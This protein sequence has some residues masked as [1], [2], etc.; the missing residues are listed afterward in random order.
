MLFSENISITRKG[1]H[2]KDKH[3]N[4][5]PLDHALSKVNT[6]FYNYWLDLK[7][8]IINSVSLLPF[9]SIRRLVFAA[10]GVKLGKGSIIHTGCKVFEPKNIIIGQD[11]KIGDSAFLDGRE[12]LQIGDHVDIASEVM[13]YNSEHDLE[14]DYFEA[15]SEPVTIGDYVFI[16]PRAIV[17]PGTS[18][19]R[20]AIIAAGAVVTKDVP[21]FAI[22][23]GIP[24]RVI[25]ERKNKNPNYI[26][27][28][29]RLFQ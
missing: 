12:K 29:D 17:L 16:G 5:L 1:L 6:R 20:G 15:K 21:D 23:G 24:A 19:G 14:S 10:S 11:T 18:I 22:V 9:W 25:G 13:I 2:F 8:L 27:G 26:L 7:L 3:G 4:R 28:R